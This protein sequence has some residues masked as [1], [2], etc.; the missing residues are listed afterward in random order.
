[1]LLSSLSG[2]IVFIIAGAI[3]ISSLRGEIS[4]DSKGKYYHKKVPKGSVKV[5]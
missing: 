2:T 1:M 3:V 4:I 5:T